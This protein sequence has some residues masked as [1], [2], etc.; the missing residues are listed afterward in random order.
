[1]IHDQK[2]IKNVLIANAGIASLYFLWG[3]IL[4]IAT[5][6]AASDYFNMTVVPGFGLWFQII[7]IAILWFVVFGEKFVVLAIAK[8]FKNPAKAPA[9]VEPSEKPVE[10]TAPAKEEVLA[11]P[12]PKEE[13]LP[14]PVEEKPA[15]VPPMEVAAP[16]E[17]ET[18]APAVEEV[19]PPAQPEEK[20][21]DV[22]V[23]P[24]VPAPSPEVPEPPVPENKE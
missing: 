11:P 8:V 7:C 2:W 22:P 17:A 13:V 3:I 23:V 14:P 1:L 16:M 9:P 21:P 20:V 12:Q 19:V 18:P 10:P 5:I 24:E 6:D 15:E 4:F